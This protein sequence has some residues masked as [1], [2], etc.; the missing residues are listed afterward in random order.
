MRPQKTPFPPERAFRESVRGGTA[1]FCSIILT[2]PVHKVVTRIMLSGHSSLYVARQLAKEGLTGLF[3]GVGPP[4]LQRSFQMAFMFGLYDKYTS[5]LK[6]HTDLSSRNVSVLAGVAAGV[7]EVSL[8]PFER[9][10][11]LLL[12]PEHNCRFINTFDAV[13]KIQPY[14]LKE[15]YRG[16]VPILARNAAATCLYFNARSFLY[17]YLPKP[18]SSQGSLANDFFCGALVGSTISTIM[19]PL[20]VAK[21]LQQQTLGG[22]YITVFS[23]LKQAALQRGGFMHMYRGVSINF[24]RSLLSW[25]LIN[26]IYGLLEG[27]I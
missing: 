9:I 16:F 25:G 10:Q 21:S 22:R 1:T 13:R 26:S 5:V 7:S 11:T 27:I 24:M 3:R 8:M 23:S 6:H 15:Y 19:F 12:A 14:G 18:Q 2:S 17:A 20:N 4:L